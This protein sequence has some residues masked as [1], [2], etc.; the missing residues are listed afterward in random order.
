MRALSRSI[1]SPVRLKRMFGHDKRL[2]LQLCEVIGRYYSRIAIV[3]SGC[4]GFHVHVM[5]F[6]YHDWFRLSESLPTDK[7]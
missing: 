7:L 2:A 3:F 1:D 5:D 4:G 6:D